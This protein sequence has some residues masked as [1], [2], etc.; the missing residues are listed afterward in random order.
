MRFCSCLLFCQ[1]NV[2]KAVP[3][4]ATLFLFYPVSLA[5]AAFPA[6]QN[7][8][9]NEWTIGGGGSDNSSSQNYRTETVT[10]PIAGDL[11]QSAAY[12]I[13]PGQLF[14]Q[15]ADVPQAPTVSNPTNWYNKLSLVI[16]PGNAPTDT[17]FA[18]AVSTDNFQTVWYVKADDTLGST[19]T[20][21]DWRTYAGWHQSTGISVLGLEPETTYTF[22]VKAEQGDFTESG[23]GP[24]SAGVTTAPLL[25]SFDI[26]VAPT[27]TE[28]SDPYIVSLGDLQPGQ[29]TT[30]TDKI[31]IDFDTNA[32]S[33][34]V[35]FVAGTN[36]GLKSD[37]TNHLIQGATGDLSAQAEGYGIQNS[38][39]NQTSGGPFTA[40]SPFS[41]SGSVVGATGTQ[42][43]PLNT[44]MAPIV[45]GRS[46]Q[47]VKTIIST[48]TPSS[49]DYQ[50]YLEL[51]AAATF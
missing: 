10:D 37:K 22:R 49:N 16:N 26:D 13:R 14:V 4:V 40:D 19:L 44:S 38:Y 36:D 12:Q 27:D 46:A 28:T 33:G 20:A 11:G 34:G 45:G 15:M 25:L 30:A 50:E 41:G 17:R 3:V 2:L 21:S 51:V 39:L 9:L 29:I 31:W 7:Y 1:K 43:I 24:T 35:V 5:L 8:R 18:V 23:W 32:Q 48:L 6:S 42:L 47:D